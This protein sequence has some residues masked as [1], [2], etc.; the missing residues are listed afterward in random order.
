MK[1]RE[2]LAIYLRSVI[3]GV[4]DSLVSTVGLLSGIA[5]SG[6]LRADII[7]T[8]LIL[9]AVEGFS[10]A[11]G[12]FLSERSVEE[13][14][15]QGSTP[16]HYAFMAGLLMFCSYV[17]AGMIPL[18]PYFFIDDHPFRYSILL[19]LVALFALGSISARKFRVHWVS[20][21]IRMLIIG[22]VAIALGIIVGGL[23]K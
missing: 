13:Y 9:L 17:I 11:A 16:I 20:R 8:G 3:L 19:S 7:V 4:E 5:V 23:L 18:L 10:M 15:G 1:P 6:V 14:T 21:G 2:L 22:G 12:E